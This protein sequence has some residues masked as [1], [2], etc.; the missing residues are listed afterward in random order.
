MNTYTYSQYIDIS[1]PC[2]GGNDTILKII[3]SY[4]NVHNFSTKIINAVSR[5]GIDIFSLMHFKYCGDNTTTMRKKYI[6]EIFNYGKLGEPKFYN[7]IEQSN[8]CICGSKI[9]YNYYITNYS[10]IYIVGSCCV[11]KFL[12]QAGS[13]KTCTICQAVHNNRKKNLCS[14]CRVIGYTSCN[15]CG[16]YSYDSTCSDCVKKYNIKCKICDSKSM[17]T[18]GTGICS[19]CLC[20]VKKC[21]ICQEYNPLKICKK[22]RIAVAKKCIVCD[23]YFTMKESKRTICT[24]CKKLYVK[25]KACK[26]IYIIKKDKVCGP[27]SKIYISKKQCMRCG[28]GKLYKDTK[29]CYR[30][31]NKINRKKCIECNKAWVDKKYNRCY[32]CYNNSDKL[33]KCVS[34]DKRINKK[35][36]CCYGCNII[37]RMA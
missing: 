16:I 35:Y 23:E 10:F 32:N 7:G 12:S 37:K 36:I 19:K 11:K 20:N 33:H 2:L 34:C 4:A 3:G 28:Y 1:S 26:T 27:C 17:I 21:K 31:N 5:L 14:H 6:N 25:C 30:C 29:Y 15:Y 8:H 22:C 18:N 9:K 13:M 24:R